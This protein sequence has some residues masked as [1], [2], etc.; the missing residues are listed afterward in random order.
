[1]KWYSKY[2]QVYN[3]PYNKEKQQPIIDEIRNNIEQLQSQA[4]VATISVIAYNEEKSLLACLWSL[5]EMKCKY[6]I[7]IIGINNNS[8][9]HTEEI[10]KLTGVTYYKEL[11]PGC[12]NARQCGLS[13]AKGKYHINIDSDTMYPPYYAETMINA[14]EKEGVVGVSALWSYIPSKGYP[15]IAL[16][17]YEFFRDVFLYLQSFQRPELSVRGAF[18]AYSTKDAQKIGI[19]TDIIRGEDGSLALELKQKGKIIVTCSRKA[20]TITD[21]GVLSGEGGLINSFKSRIAKAIK[22]IPGLFVTKKDYKDDDDNLI[23]RTKN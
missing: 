8:T 3:K 1:M 13:N 5:S 17:F 9:D 2:L 21:Y 14:L 22:N 15:K 20:R 19:R 23:G 7:E 11:T 4:P 10:F 16:F 6:P 12:G 18:F